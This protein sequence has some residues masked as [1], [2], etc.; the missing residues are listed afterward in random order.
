MCICRIGSGRE[1]SYHVGFSNNE[2]SSWS[3][4]KTI[5]PW[6]VFPRVLTVGK[7]RIVLTGGR[8]GLMPWICDDG[9]GDTWHAINLAEHHNNT[10][11]DTSHHFEQQC[12]L[13]SCRE[14]LQSTTSY[15]GMI[16]L[17]DN[18]L[19]ISYDRLGNG[20]EGAPGSFGE[21]DTVFTVCVSL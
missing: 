6:S 1:F 21:H 8:P 14:S 17:S 3:E 15:T 12:V 5:D 9:L 16:A 20:W 10:L 13:A 2:G 7:G 18:E 19:L 11:D 4:P